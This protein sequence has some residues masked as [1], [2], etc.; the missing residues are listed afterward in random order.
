MKDN[1]NPRLSQETLDAI[2][3]DETFLLSLGLFLNRKFS[4]IQRWIRDNH[5]SLTTPA[6]IGFIAKHLGTSQ[7]SLIAKPKK[8]KAQA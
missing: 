7:E 3:T 2:R 6:C 5:E 4:T 1:T 8:I